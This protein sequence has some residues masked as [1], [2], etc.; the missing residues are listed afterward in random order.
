MT[1][2]RAALRKIAHAKLEDYIGPHAM[3]MAL[4]SIAREALS[5]QPAPVDRPCPECKAESWAHY[6][7]CSRAAAQADAPEGER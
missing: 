2:V 3:A 6:D 7:S 1:P 5:R 4:V